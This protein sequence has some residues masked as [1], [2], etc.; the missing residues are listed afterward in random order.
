VLSQDV[1]LAAQLGGFPPIIVVKER[2][3]LPAR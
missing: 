1:V 3:I 2:Y